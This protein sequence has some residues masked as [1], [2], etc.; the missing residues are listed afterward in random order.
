MCYDADN[1]LTNLTIN[2]DTEEDNYTII[3]TTSTGINSMNTI[4]DI[5][6]KCSRKRF[7]SKVYVGF[8]KKKRN[9]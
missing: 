3:G 2:T 1:N 6:F 7:E 8:F 4:Y 9:V 5:D